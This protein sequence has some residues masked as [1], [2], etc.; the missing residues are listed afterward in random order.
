MGSLTRDGEIGRLFLSDRW[1]IPQYK[2]FSGA[3][4]FSSRMSLGVGADS[5]VGVRIQRYMDGMNSLDVVD[6]VP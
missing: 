4:F 1:Q 2:L 3:L 5:L 6:E